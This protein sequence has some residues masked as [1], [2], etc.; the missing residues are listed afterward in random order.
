MHKGWVATGVVLA[1]TGGTAGF[2]L[3]QSGGGA[4]DYSS[5]GGNETGVRPTAVGLPEIGESGTVGAS[6]YVNSLKAYHDS[7]QYDKDLAAVGAA[8]K[9]YLDQR[10]AQNGKS[11]LTC[12]V[13]YKRT[14]KRQNH[15]L[16]YRRFKHC[17]TTQRPNQK[18]AVVFDIDETSLSNY[19]FLAAA[20]FSSAGLVP[21]AVAGTS[22]AI[23]PTLAL[24]REAVSKGVAVFFITGRPSQVA[25]ISENNLKSAGYNQGWNGIS[26]KPSG[27]GTEAFKSGARAKIEQQGYDIAI[28]IGDQESDL[29]GGHADHDFKLPNPYYFIS[30]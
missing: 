22:P 20:G 1:L 25:T 24:Y 16:V 7:G 10:I 12:R 4:S 28:D 26:F 23:Q 19:S 11:T 29:D 18:L 9:A 3:A 15:H 17:T 8:A 6:E 27:V 21:A 5:S 14:H 13:S 2:A 30:D